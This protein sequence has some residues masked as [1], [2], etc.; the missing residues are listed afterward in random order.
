MEEHAMYDIQL[1][2]GKL[3]LR[4]QGKKIKTDALSVYAQLNF[5][6][7]ALDLMQDIA[8]FVTTKSIVKFVQT[9]LKHNKM[10]KDNTEHYKTYCVSKMHT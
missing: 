3:S 6:N 10:I 9:S 8:R 2:L 4:F 7:L 1:C 5:A